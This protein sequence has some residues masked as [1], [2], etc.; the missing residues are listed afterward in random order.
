MFL[1]PV[2]EVEIKWHIG[3]LKIKSS[4]GNDGISNSL[5]KLAIDS[6]LAPLAYLV[7]LSFKQGV[8]PNDLKVARVVPVF[9]K[10]DSADFWFSEV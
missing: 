1:T 2:T 3:K 9:K 6:L 4:A 7:N 10:G 5:L 8:F